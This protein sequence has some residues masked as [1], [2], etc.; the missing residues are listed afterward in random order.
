MEDWASRSYHNTIELPI[1]DDRREQVEP[2]VEKFSQ[3]VGSNFGFDKIF[4]LAFMILGGTVLF[5]GI[6][7]IYAAICFYTTEG[8]ECM[9]ILTDGGREYGKYPLSIYGKS[10]L[11]FT[12]YIIPYA[13]FQYYPFLYL[14]G[15]VT[16]RR[17]LL[18]PF[19]A[20]AFY[21]PCYIIWRVGVGH[22]KSTGS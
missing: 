9:N 19:G 10:M 5:S 22:Y 11:K 16:D 7:L 21:I 18:L 15:R 2:S 14:I 8:L 17:Y 3:R 20:V 6:F 13:C 12:T 1:T 4:L